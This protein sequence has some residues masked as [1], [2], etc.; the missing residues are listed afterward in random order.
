MRS[1]IPAGTVVNDPLLQH[2]EPEQVEARL[3][4]LGAVLEGHFQLSS[5][6]HSNRYFQCA[7]VLQFPGLA[8]E[9]GRLLGEQFDELEI[10][11]VVS[12]AVGGVLIG[13]EVA[14]ALGR[15]H[16][17]A[18]R[19]DGALAVRRGFD[20]RKA[21]RAL[22][23]DDVLTRGTSFFELSKLVERL[24]ATTVGLGVIVDR[25]ESGLEIPVPVASLMAVEVQTHEP[26]RC[27]LCQANV[28]LDSPGS[29]HAT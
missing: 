15:R 20:V 29:R 14:R 10:D 7:Q 3:R 2:L 16:V 23:V 27:P 11:L 8:K 13:H 26:D 24:E 5:G 4:E 9:L 19:R 1:Q 25:R 28:P 18:E 6:L 12:P 21:E 22:I 17:F